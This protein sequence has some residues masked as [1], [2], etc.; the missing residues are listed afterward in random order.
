MLARS[1]MWLLAALPLAGQQPNALLE[2]LRS[3]PLPADQRQALEA[4]FSARDFTRMEQIARARPD[5]DTAALLGALE[6]VAGRMTQAVESF[7][8][9]DAVK[10]LDDRDRFTLAM[11]LAD[12]SDVN[13]ARAELT[14]LNVS[15]PDHP[16]YLYWLARLDYNQRLYDNAVDKL[17][18]VIGMDPES[19]RAYDNLGLCYDMMGRTDDALD[20]FAKAAEFNRKLPSPSGWP[21][22]NFGYLLL[23]L[24]RFHEA[25]QQLREALKYDP[26]LSVA[27]YRLGQVLETEGHDDAAIEEYKAAAGDVKLAAPMYCL[28]RL[29]RR[30]GRDAEAKRCF[31]E[32]R[33]RKA[34]DVDSL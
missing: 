23:R 28:G 29:Y 20:A 32:F 22:Q 34:L 21:P 16:L 17:K 26:H 18:R 9:S 2:R 19:A 3:A 25:E 11:A 24:Q 12:L 13:G 5:P 6:F 4:S 15:H 14:R 10:S 33:R 31:T 30:Q 7:R 1:A 8:R 27:H